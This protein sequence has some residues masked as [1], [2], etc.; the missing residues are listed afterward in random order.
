MS[1]SIHHRLMERV[2]ELTALHRTARLLQ[3]SERP[4]DAVIPDVVELLPAAWQYPA[5][6]AGR[7]RC[8]EQSWT[9][10][11]FRETAWSQREIFFLRDGEQ[12]A[13]EV[14]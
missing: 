8:G 5:I 4:L 9:T 3:D 10:P 7:I 14:F 6:T 13:I 1:E 11:G 12:G 2:K